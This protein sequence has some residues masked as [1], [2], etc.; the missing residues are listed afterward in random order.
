[1]Q[2]DCDLTYDSLINTETF[3]ELIKTWISTRTSM[4]HSH[5]VIKWYTIKDKL[6]QTYISVYTDVFWN[7]I[8]GTALLTYHEFL[9]NAGK[10]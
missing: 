2:S 7:V 6:Y 4:A 8:P 1:M 3:S 5:L 9:Q 10:F